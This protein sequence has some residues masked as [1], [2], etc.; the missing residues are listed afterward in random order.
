MC[1]QRSKNGR[2]DVVGLFAVVHR[3][4]LLDKLDIKL[5]THEAMAIH[6]VLV[7][8]NIRFH[9]HDAI[10]FKARRIRSTA[11]P[12]VLPYTINLL[13]IES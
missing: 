12:R 9:A 13:I 7:E 2:F 8:R 11:S 6:H 1:Q 5:T 3:E 10:F 4:T